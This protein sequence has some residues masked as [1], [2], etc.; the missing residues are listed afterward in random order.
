VG[1]HTAPWN[2]AG[3][4]VKV[5]K[6][7]VLVVDDD[8]DVRGFLATFLELEGFEVGTAENGAEAL[9]QV[10]EQ[11]PDVMILDLMMPVMDG[12]DCCRR[13]RADART[14]SLPVIVVSASQDHDFRL[15]DVGA[16]AFLSKPFDLADLIGCLQ[17][18]SLTGGLQ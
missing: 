8:P 12:W 17:E 16:N 11:Q 2:V 6:P 15:W 10:G 5:S 18:H 9:Q 13:L 14:R 1:W 3:E 4:Q 7:R